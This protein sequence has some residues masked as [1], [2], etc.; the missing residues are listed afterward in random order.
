[1]FR[2]STKVKILQQWPFWL[3]ARWVQFKKRGRSGSVTAERA[4]LGIDD[5]IDG[6]VPRMKALLFLSP[7]AWL[8]AK[9]EAPHISL[10]NFT[11]LTFEMVKA[12]NKEGFSVDIVDYRDPI[13]S[14]GDDG[15]PPHDYQ[16]VV[17]H[18]GHCKE[19]M[20]SLPLSVPVLQYVSGAFWPSFNAETAERYDSFQKRRGIRENLSV[21][22]SLAG[23]AEGDQWLIDRANFFFSDTLPRM[24]AGYGAYRHKF[25]KTGYGAYVD[26]KLVV[27][28]GERDFGVACKNFIYVGGTGGNIQKGLDVLLEAF[29]QTPELNLYIYCKVEPEVIG[30]C[31]EFLDRPNVH[32]IYHW[33]KGRQGARKLAALMP[34]IAFSVHAPI[35]TG[36]GT[37]YMASIGSGLIP[38]GY[39]DLSPDDSWTVLSPGWQPEELADS[40]RRASKKSA[41]WCQAA[42]EKAVVVHRE[43]WSPEAVHGRF[44]ELI[45]LAKSDGE[46]QLRESD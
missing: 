43:N 23:I 40:L 41:A 20:E 1:M 3:I 12:L 34:T 35:N 44:V 29:S 17:A 25:F 5:F 15:R 37:A 8:K 10:F 33:C 16:L 22:R 4:I 2:N 21:R 11:G 32:Y 39:V 42:S 31:R 38:V 9:A 26:E 28:P 18:G 45:Q 46:K 13:S 36:L 14:L 7:N 30:F 6:A 27:K 24:I 19:L